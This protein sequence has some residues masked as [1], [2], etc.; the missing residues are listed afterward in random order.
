MIRTQIQLTEEQ[1]RALRRLAAR[2]GVSMAAVIRGVLDEALVAPRVAQLE[3]ARAAM[4][5]FQSGTTRVSI[6]HDRELD[7]A[8]Q[9]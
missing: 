6:E 4:G 7:D 9:R 5:R 2:R 1:G 8:Y 3:R